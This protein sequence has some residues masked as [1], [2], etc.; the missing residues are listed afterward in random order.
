MAQHPIFAK[1]AQKAR[2]FCTA[3]LAATGL[4]ATAHAALAAP[5]HAPA[6]PPA[7]AAPSF[8]AEQ[9]D[10]GAQIYAGTCAMCHGAAL[11]GAHDMPPLRGLFVARWANT[12]LN[13]LY[14]YITHAMPLMAPGTLPPQDN[15]DVIAFLLRE[16]GTEPGHTPLPADENRL[17][18]MVFPTPNALPP[19]KAAQPGKAPRTR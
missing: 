4:V 5:R 3:L 8:T 7:P 1:Q 19:V 12:S 16:N 11:E 2:G 13:K 15:I 6:A 18:Q 17:A 14:A 9:A 10:H